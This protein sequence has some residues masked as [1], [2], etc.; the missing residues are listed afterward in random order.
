MIT[1]KILYIFL[2]SPLKPFPSSEKSIPIAYESPSIKISLYLRRLFSKIISSYKE[3][4]SE[5][6]KKYNGVHRGI[7]ID[8]L[9]LDIEKVEVNYLKIKESNTFDWNCIPRI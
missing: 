1:S 2:A 8:R 9:L 3:L 6:F 7:D 5:K 4:R